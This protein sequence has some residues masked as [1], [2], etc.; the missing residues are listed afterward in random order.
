MQANLSRETNWGLGELE[1]AARAVFW[2]DRTFAPR[3]LLSAMAGA[4]L[5]TSPLQ[6]SA[7]GAPLSLDAQLGTGSWD[8]QAGL[9]ALG[10]SGDWSGL[11]SLIGV[12]PSQGHEG[13]RPGTALHSSLFVQR[14]LTTWLALRLGG[15]ARLEAPSTY[16]EEGLHGGGLLVQASPDL[17]FRLTQDGVLQVGARLPLLNRLNDGLRPSPVVQAT[18]AFDL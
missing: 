1:L 13:F 12:L 16:P 3:L 6:H 2:R 7:H 11:F 14:Q 18:L 4:K 10:F 5:P 8:A 15:D 9:T 17:L